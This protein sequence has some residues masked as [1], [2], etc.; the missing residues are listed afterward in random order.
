MDRKRLLPSEFYFL[1]ALEEEMERERNTDI[2]TRLRMH[3]E[4]TRSH[5]FGDL[6]HDI[7]GESADEIERLRSL[8]ERLI[9]RVISTK[10]EDNDG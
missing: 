1:E 6:I 9:G 10:S 5:R 8:V 3:S 7:Y 2:V 4:F